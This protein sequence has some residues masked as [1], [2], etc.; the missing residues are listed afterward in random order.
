[1]AASN[2]V[3]WFEIYVNEMERARDFYEAVLKIKCSMLPMPQEI[4][5]NITMVAFP[6][7]MNASGASGALVKMDDFKAGGNSTVVYF[8]CDDRAVEENRVEKAG[9]KVFQAKHSIGE[10]GFVS[11][12][13]DTEGNMFGLH[14]MS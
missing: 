8:N 13:Y 6:M 7:N 9:G 4:Q 2:P 5:G 1:M 3:V 14:S 10:Y 12:A 11:L